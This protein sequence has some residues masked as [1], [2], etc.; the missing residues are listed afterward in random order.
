[1]VLNART[2]CC[3]TCKVILILLWYVKYGHSV[4]NL[5]QIAL[6]SCTRFIHSGRCGFTVL[7]LKHETF[8]SKNWALSTHPSH[9]LR[10]NA[11]AVN[12]SKHQFH[13]FHTRATA[14]LALQICWVKHMSA[15]EGVNSSKDHSECWMVRYD[16]FKNDAMVADVYSCHW[17]IWLYFKRGVWKKKL[18]CRCDSATFRSFPTAWKKMYLIH[19]SCWHSQARVWQL[20]VG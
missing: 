12:M 18:H 6:F 11:H 13:V 3:S 2:C 4:P 19:Y 5:C 15:E 7:D 17:G 20:H 9:V 16:T 8:D 1:M 14:K 10:H